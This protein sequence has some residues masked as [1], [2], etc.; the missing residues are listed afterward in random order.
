MSECTKL[1]NHIHY[2]FTQFRNSHVGAVMYS[3]RSGD[4]SGWLQCDGRAVSRSTYNLLFDAI[5]T[6]F[7]AGDGL[8]TFNLPDARDRVLGVQGSSHSIGDD[9]GS[10]TIT[11]TVGQ[12]AAHNHVATM[13]TNGSHTHS[14]T[15]PG[16]AHN[17]VNNT[18]NQTTDDAFSTET[19]AD[20]ADLN[21]VTTT[22]TTGITINA[23]GD[24]SHD[25][26]V[27]NTGN[28]D[29]I[30]I[31]QPTLF[32]GNLFIYCGNCVN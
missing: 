11:L 6:Q 8:T 17:Y 12:L 3:A 5:G 2:Q 25:I 22:S 16:H 32:I 27:N 19:A 13:T 1:L 9:I 20:N 28:T 10:E 26:T 29:P 31:V 23:N 15:D 4:F 18:N 7:G 30:N 14:I 24:H 21:A